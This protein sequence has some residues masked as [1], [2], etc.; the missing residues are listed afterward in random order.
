MWLSIAADDIIGKIFVMWLPI[1]AFVGIG[2]EHS[3]ANMFF[4]PAGMFAGADVNL[5]QFIFMNV[6]PVTLGNIIG[7]GVFVAW[8]YHYLYLKKEDNLL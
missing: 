1:M 7:A 4:I 2:F 3:V 6:L 5:L 8:I